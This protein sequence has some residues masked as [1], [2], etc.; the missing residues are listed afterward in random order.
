MKHRINLKDW[1][2][3]DIDNYMNG[4]PFFSDFMD[5]SE[6]NKSVGQVFKNYDIKEI[7]GKQDVMSLKPK[8]DIYREFLETKEPRS[9]WEMPIIKREEA[10]AAE[11]KAKQE[12]EA[13]ALEKS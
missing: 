7:A 8:I 2:I 9:N 5:E 12:Q 11:L 1:R 10:A 3:A 4:N 13:A 6:W